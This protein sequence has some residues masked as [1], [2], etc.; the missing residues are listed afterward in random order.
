LE[1]VQGLA[2]RCGRLW[3]LAGVLE[4]RDE[5][6]IG[7]LASFEGVHQLIPERAQGVGFLFGAL[8]QRCPRGKL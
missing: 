3:Q 1:V 6:S 4:L 2:F 7:S 5:L 8:G